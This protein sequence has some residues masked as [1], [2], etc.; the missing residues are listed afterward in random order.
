MTRKELM[1]LPQGQLAK[2]C[3][4]QGLDVSGSKS[5]LADRLAESEEAQVPAEPEAPVSEPETEPEAE[6][7]PEPEVS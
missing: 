1:R 7:E 4:N 5:D 3:R 6:P 2:M